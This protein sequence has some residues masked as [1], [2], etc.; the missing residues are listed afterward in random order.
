MRDVAPAPPAEPPVQC[1][2]RRQTPQLVPSPVLP[3]SPPVEGSGV[4]IPRRSGREGKIPVRKG[5]VYGETRH[6]T[7]IFKD[8]EKRESWKKMVETRGQPSRPRPATVPLSRDERLP[9]PSSSK[10][11]PRSRDEPA[12]CLPSKWNMPRESTPIISSS[13]SN[14]EAENDSGSTPEPIPAESNPQPLP[15]APN[16]MGSEA[17]S[18]K[19]DSEEDNDDDEEESSEYEDE[20]SSLEE[21]KAALRDPTRT[22]V[23]ELCREGGADLM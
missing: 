22:D 4:D 13:S 17:H 1:A 19:D 21:V 16:E 14:D 11:L 6:P 18:E 10:S 12:R 3:Q 2:S 7:D 8:I 15:G 20:D 23:A 5:N 9:G